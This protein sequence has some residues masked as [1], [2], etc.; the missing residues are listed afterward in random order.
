MST[1]P[2]P[3]HDQEYT[4]QLLAHATVRHVPHDHGSS[5]PAVCFTMRVSS[6]GN[7]NVELPFGQGQEDAAHA[8]AA[9]LPAG[10]MVTVQACI[11]HIH[12]CVRNARQV[13]LCLPQTDTQ[14]KELAL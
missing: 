10:A 8:K 4:G 7:I 9:Q 6:R 12:L 1:E 5:L 13:A 11:T 2:T 3:I 14:Q